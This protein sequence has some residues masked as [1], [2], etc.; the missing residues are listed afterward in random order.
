MIN[1]RY[2]QFPPLPA[3]IQ[4]RGTALD[5]QYEGS[6]IKAQKAEDASA[7]ERWLSITGQIAPIYPE[8]V[9]VVEIDEAVRY[10]GRKGGVPSQ[11]IKAQEQVQ[12][13]RQQRAQQQQMMEEIAQKQA[14]G[15]AAQQMGKGIQEL[16]NANFKE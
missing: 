8:V 14:A 7:V 11:L 9:D 3:E 13:V 15:E 4:E 10:L 2:K 12:S 5:I 16:R 1:Y 6:M